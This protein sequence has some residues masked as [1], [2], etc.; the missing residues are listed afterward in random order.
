MGFAGALRR[1][2]LVALDTDHLTQQ[3]EGLAVR[4]A[5]SKTDQE[6]RGQVIAVPRVGDSHYCPVQAVLDWLT[7]LRESQRVKSLAAGNISADIVLFRRA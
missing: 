6:G 1:S 7:R 5:S 2:Q 3:K 4:I